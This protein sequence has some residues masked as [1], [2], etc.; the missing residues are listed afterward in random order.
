MKSTI[1]RQ[2]RIAVLAWT[3][4]P[5]DRRSAG[6]RRRVSRG[7][8]PGAPT[9]DGSPLRSRNDAG[10]IGRRAEAAIAAFREAIQHDDLNQPDR[11][12]CFA[13]SS[14]HNG[15]PKRLQRSAASASV[16]KDP[17]QSTARST[18]ADHQFEQ[19]SKSGRDDPKG[20]FR[21][22][23]QR[24]DFARA[25]VMG[26]ASLPPRRRFGPPASRQTR[27]WPRT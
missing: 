11:S 23:D 15:Q 10:R 12:A 27:N 2:V 1:S 4:P 14:W 16:R 20:L 18:V 19:L 5:V 6:R 25:I 22:S 3:C 26:G 13:S 21:L 9:V 24:N 7:N 17:R 8:P